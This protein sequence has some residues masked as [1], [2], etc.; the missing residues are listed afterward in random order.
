M[1]KENKEITAWQIFCLVI[2]TGWMVSLISLVISHGNT[3]NN[4]IFQG[5]DDRF[6]DFLNHIA[7]VSYGKDSLYQLN[8]NVCFPPL[9]YLFFWVLSLILPENSIGIWQPLAANTYSILIYV[10][11][12]LFTVILLFYIMMK[13]LQNTEKS[14]MLMLSVIFS[15]VFIAGVL[16]RGSLAVLIS[17]SVIVALV[18][19]NSESKVKREIA[20]LLI[21]LAAGFKIYPA[22]FGL[23]YL[24]EKR[25]KE[26]IRLIIY[27]VVFF[28][29]P[30]VFF[31]GIQGL[32]QMF[33]NQ[34]FLHTNSSLDGCINIAALVSCF[35]DSRAIM[36]GISL[37]GL[38]VLIVA[39]L[40]QKSMWKRLL[41]LS[42][43]MVVVPVW[44]GCYT[45]S[46][47]VIPL[48]FFIKERSTSF[49]AAD[50]FYSLMFA[51][52]FSIFQF[53]VG[54]IRWAYAVCAIGVYLLAAYSIVDA[55][56]LGRMSLP[57]RNRSDG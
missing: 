40:I 33:E 12:V 9:A 41:I 11:F 49:A 47:L 42:L 5:G 53:P 57:F 16:E 31:E 10:G 19:Q 46:Y 3:W 20:L 55:F 1:K 52:T 37:A 21:A 22:V 17:V 2:V 30:F 39:F 23:L 7:Y 35:T 15:C 44:S 24:K 18:L 6:A 43:M 13:I 32:R 36:Q 8:Y 38:A 4:I 25:W 34:M 27:G 45:V 56:L 51:L 29:V 28:F 26:A 48:I 54:N 14:L 50:A